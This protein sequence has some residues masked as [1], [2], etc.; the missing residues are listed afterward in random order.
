M[1]AEAN[2]I[3][4]TDSQA[5]PPSAVDDVTTAV[6]KF[7]RLAAGLAELKNKY[8]AVVFDVTTT[9]GMKDATSARAEVRAPRYELEKARIAG[10]RKILALGKDLDERA[11]KIEVELTAL[12]QPID[13]QIKAEEA[14]REEEKKRKAEAERA[15][16]AGI[17]NEIDRH[18]RNAPTASFG[19]TAEQLNTV[20]REVVA[21]EIT[22]ERFAEFAE[23]AAIAKE[24]ALVKLRT[25]H[26]LQEQR[27]A[28]HARLELERE[29]L[30]R[31]RVAQQQAQLVQQEANRLERERIAAEEAASL[32]K[33]QAEDLERQR[34][35]E[36]SMAKLR[37]EREENERIAREHKAQQERL[38]AERRA[39]D[40]R[41]AAEHRREQQALQR[42]QELQQIRWGEI[43][44]IGHQVMI[45]TMGR[46]GVRAGGTRECI[47]DTLAETE[48]WSVTVENF[49]PLYP[50]AVSA[51]KTAC[52]AITRELQAWDARTEAAR[53]AA[54]QAA[55]VAPEPVAQLAE[56]TEAEVDAVLSTSAAPALPEA[57]APTANDIVQVVSN[58]YGVD[59]E[60]AL[61]WCFNAFDS[62]GK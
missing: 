41:R 15:R 60:Q 58:A 39:E 47:V 25:M 50:M 2:T 31:Q 17:Q 28:E 54:E 59:F 22:A 44:A 57:W 45:A 21:S 4:Q 61:V 53:V 19:L 11:A 3:A 30:E 43:N 52:E 46:S 5:P 12:E 10:K 56:A 1:S 18:F 24:T 14:R 37:A 62:Q 20:I 49:G 8:A 48:R 51:R 23:P 16:V 42:E 32:A 36:E 9:K 29:E 38:D 35:I 6:A 34:Q 40:E 27:E 7:D 26:V 33:R 55:A 13:A